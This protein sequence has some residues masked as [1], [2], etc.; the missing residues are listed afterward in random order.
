MTTNQKFLDTTTHN[1]AWVFKRYQAD[2][3]ELTAPFQRNPVW[4]LAQKSYLIDTILRGYPIPELYIQEFTD[5]EG[6]DRYV[7]VD[8]QQR[9]RAYIEYIGNEFALVGS[10]KQEVAK[11]G[12]RF[13]Q[14][15]TDEKKAI[16]NYNF[17]VRKLPD[18]SDTEI[19]SVFSRINRNTVALNQQEL[20]HSTYWG[21]FIRTMEV[22]AQHPRWHDIGIFSANDIRRMLDVEYIS[23]L[24]IAYLHGPQN[25]KSSLDKW[26]MAYEDEFDESGDILRVFRKFLSDILLVLPNVARLRYSKKSDFYTLFQYFSMDENR[27]G[28]SS[29]NLGVKL[30]TFAAMV[31]A[32]IEDPE[33]EPEPPP[34]VRSYVMGVERAA[35]D[36]GNRKRRLFALVEA[37]RSL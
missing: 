15:E 26:Y 30:D 37:V 1:L 4:S 3:L 5:E 9:L 12:Y 31:D 33:I 8:G 7:V 10:G 19:R 28:I 13:E 35:S 27:H 18:M 14:L 24:A 34:F 2:E 32:Y 23:E 20:R 25:K 6:D 29:A 11:L 17:V 16:Y 22:I 21:P 36:L